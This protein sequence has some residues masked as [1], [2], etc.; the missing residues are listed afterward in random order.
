MDL[1]LSVC[2]HF[3][4]KSISHCENSISLR[5]WHL[6]CQLALGLLEAYAIFANCQFPWAWNTSQHSCFKFSQAL[7]AKRQHPWALSRDW[8]NPLHKKEMFYC[9]RDISWCSQNPHTN[10]CLNMAWTD[11]RGDIFSEHGTSTFQ[12]MLKWKKAHYF[13]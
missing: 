5:H 13:L 2:K 12:C 3:S 9:V 6:D 10:N 4:F 1:S 7:K 11:I 8:R